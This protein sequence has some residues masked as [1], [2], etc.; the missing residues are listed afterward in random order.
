MSLVINS[1][2]TSQPLH[3][4]GIHTY[5]KGRWQWVN[6]DICRDPS[7]SSEGVTKPSKA[8]PKH[9]LR[10]YLDR[11]RAYLPYVHGVSALSSILPSFPWPPLNPTSFPNL[12]PVTRLGVS[13]DVTH[14]LG[15]G[16]PTAGGWRVVETAA[17]GSAMESQL[18]TRPS[19]GLQLVRLRPLKIRIQYILYLWLVRGKVKR[20][21]TVFNA[22]GEQTSFRRDFLSRMSLQIR[23]VF[24]IIF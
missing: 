7:T 12:G 20:P 4:T 10:R 3:G 2:H 6:V 21:G 1:N 18:S 24:T 15:P 17:M 13:A 5:N 23:A 19:V 8:S 9:F 11:Y 16:D 22:K 14:Q